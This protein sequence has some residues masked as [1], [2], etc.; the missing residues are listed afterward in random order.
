MAQDVEAKIV[1]VTDNGN[2]KEVQI[3]F[4]RKGYAI[5]LHQSQARVVNR[6]NPSKYR[7]RFNSSNTPI[8]EI[9]QIPTDFHDQVALCRHYYEEDGITGTVIDLMIQFSAGEIQHV[10]DDNS[11]KEFFD[12]LYREADLDQVIKWIL[13]EYY[14]FGNS[15]PYRTLHK[16]ETKTKDGNKIPKYTWTVLNPENVEV[17][18][19]LLF[20]QHVITLRPTRELIDMVKSRKNNPVAQK[21]LKDFPEEFIMAIDKNENI[22]L[23]Q[24]LVSHISRNKQPYQRYAVPF[25]MRA[26]TPLK[27][28]EKLIQMD[29]STADGVINQ[30]VTVTIGSDEFPATQEELD[31]LSDLLDTPSKAYALLWN[32]TLNVKFHRPEADIFNPQKYEQVNSDILAAFG[33]TR[34]L[35]DGGDS[36]YG[37]TWVSITSLIERLEWGRNDIKKWLENEYKKIAE[38]QGLPSY[39]KVRFSKINLQEDKTV[40]NILMQLYDRGLISAETIIEETGHEF[41]VE[42]DRM[43]KEKPLKEKGFFTSQSP[44]QERKEPGRPDGAEDSETRERNPLPAPHG[45]S[46]KVAQADTQREEILMN[47][48][49]ESLEELYVRAK[50]EIK[51]GIKNSTDDDWEDVVYSVLLSFM[52]DMNRQGDSYLTTAFEFIYRNTTNEYYRNNPDAVEKLNSILAENSQ[53]VRKFVMDLSIKLRNAMQNPTVFDLDAVVDSEFASMHYRLKLFGSEGVF[54]TKVESSVLAHKRMGF[55]R[56]IWNATFENTCPDCLAKHNV[57]YS[58]DE[59]MAYFPAHVNCKCFLQFIQ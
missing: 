43:E 18:G 1:G 52:L 4:A 30:L 50:E 56:A 29:L 25:L 19:S 22:P 9:D 59:V 26:I 3:Q 42:L 38:E 8:Y 21:I 17:S 16:E 46:L 34:S 55:S 45:A 14:L 20:N 11:V 49:I 15:F 53:Y 57:V 41:K 54:R 32:H 13:F 37:R 2:Q 36:G 31:A 10:S 23:D 47:E 40:K 28:K 5:P 24:N 27:I 44:Y 39:P 58:L 6:Y 48:Y 51:Q 35:I 7:S 12:N 33:I